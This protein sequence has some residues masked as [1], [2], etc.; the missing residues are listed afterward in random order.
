MTVGG[1]ALEIAL[2]GRFFLGDGQLIIGQGEMVHAD[3]AVA[4]GG[5]L[6]D[7]SFQHLKLGGGG[8]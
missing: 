7:G 8:G 2:Q 5:Q 1:V 4:C 6:F 3:I